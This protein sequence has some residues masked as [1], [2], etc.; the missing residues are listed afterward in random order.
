MGTVNIRLGH[1]DPKPTGVCWFRTGD[2]EPDLIE[3][4]LRRFE[5]LGESS[6]F[7]EGLDSARELRKLPLLPG[8][9]DCR[10]DE[11]GR[12]QD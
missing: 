8:I 10:G 1:E 12:A 6:E 11:I 7:K 3:E 2:L 9:P 5:P 4:D